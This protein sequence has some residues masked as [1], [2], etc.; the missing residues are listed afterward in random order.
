M[1]NLSTQQPD[2]LNQLNVVSFEVVFTKLPSVQYFCQRITLPT[3][4]LGETNEATPFMN[5]PVEGDTLTFEALTLS[6]IVDE[7]LQ[8]YIEIYNWMTAL[9]FP[10]DYSQFQVLKDIVID[11]A[12]QP[13]SKYSDLTII[14]YK[15]L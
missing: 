11:A 5:L 3:V 9:G 15:Y 7:D 13:D 1:T 12:S 14:L 4:I 8:N 10:R 6:F 2:N